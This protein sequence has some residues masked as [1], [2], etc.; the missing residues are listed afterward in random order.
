MSQPESPTA[1]LV[2]EAQALV[3]KVQQDLARSAAFYRDNKIDPE[4]AA[5]VLAGFVGP[6]EQAEVAR[7]VK[8]DQEAIER[9]VSEAAARA[10][11]E[12]PAAPVAAPRRQRP[13]V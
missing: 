11:F 3:I 5:Q 9:E 13:M 1:R 10:R 4:K 2:N 12:T 7:L 8:E 6:R